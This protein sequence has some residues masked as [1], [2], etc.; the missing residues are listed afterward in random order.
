MLISAAQNG[1]MVTGSS[2]TAV[3][4]IAGDFCLVFLCGGFGAPGGR[5][6]ISSLYRRLFLF[7]YE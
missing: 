6:Q 4:L 5:L 7:G 3:G 1:E 2:H